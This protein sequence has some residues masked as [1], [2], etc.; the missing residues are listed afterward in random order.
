MVR[1]RNPFAMIKLILKH[2]NHRKVQRQQRKNH[3]KYRHK[4]LHQTSYIK[5]LIKKIDNPSIVQ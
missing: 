2:G 5:L 3:P 4:P 1:G